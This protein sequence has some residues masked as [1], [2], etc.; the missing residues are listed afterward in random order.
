MAGKS[1]RFFGTRPKWMLTHPNGKFMA[2]QA[3]LGLPMKKF[4][5]IIFTHLKSHEEEYHFSKSFESEMRENG[6]NNFT[7]LPMD[8][9]TKDVVETVQLTI[10]KAH[11]KDSILVKDC[12]N[13]I[14]YKCEFSC[15]ENHV[16]FVPTGF[17]KKV[18]YPSA[19]SY[20][21][22]NAGGIITKIAE[23]KVISPNFCCGAYFFKSASDFL[24]GANGR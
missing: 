16:C 9:P 2:I 4:S 10:K 5:R 12:D 6:L 22:M 7:L 19:K 11:I 1:S 18:D 23:K 17:V 14:E 20:I 3:I 21:E 15:R 8:Y 13:Y 24:I